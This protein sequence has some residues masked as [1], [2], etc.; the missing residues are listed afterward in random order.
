MHARVELSKRSSFK[1]SIMKYI[2]QYPGVIWLLL[3]CCYTCNRPG[4]EKNNLKLSFNETLFIRTLGWWTAWWKCH[5]L[6]S[7]C[8]GFHS[9]P[10]FC[11]LEGW[12]VWFSGMTFCTL[13][14]KTRIWFSWQFENKLCVLFI[15]S[16]CLISQSTIIMQW[17]IIVL[18]HIALRSYTATLQRGLC[19]FLGSCLWL[20]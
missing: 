4:K 14:S 12:L 2:Q 19:N 10:T 15:F 5:R 7:S 9:V 13:V 1:T 17:C 11:I 20:L 6:L 16:P 18:H 3:P 8:P